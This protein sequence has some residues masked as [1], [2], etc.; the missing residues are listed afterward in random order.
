MPSTVPSKPLLPSPHTDL[1]LPPSAVFPT[2]VSNNFF[3][4]GWLVCFS[5]LY[6]PVQLPQTE[7]QKEAETKPGKGNLPYKHQYQTPHKWLSQSPADTVWLKPPEVSPCPS[8]NYPVSSI[9]D[10]KYQ[11]LIKVRV[12]SG[13]AQ[14]QPPLGEF[15]HSSYELEHVFDISTGGTS[16]SDIIYPR[17]SA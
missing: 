2:I 10:C 13:V 17:V 5:P 1:S 7:R 8:T 11:K 9:F 4:K 3:K 6:R 12:G 15:L 14:L 16:L